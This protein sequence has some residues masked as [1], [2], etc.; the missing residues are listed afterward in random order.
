MSGDATGSPDRPGDD[1]PGRGRRLGLDVGTV[2]IGVAVSDPD[3]ILATPVETVRAE[4]GTGDHPGHELGR[5]LDIAE[6]NAVVEVVVGLPVT[7]RGR[8]TAS[9]RRARVYAE[10]LRE[11]LGP[12]VPVRLADERLS[13]MAATQAMQASGVSAKKGRGRIDQAAAVHILQGWLDARRRTIS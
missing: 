7:L 5:I 8:D 3:G 4:P 9:T 12:S 2:R 1:D 10:T 11:E 13:T 6:D